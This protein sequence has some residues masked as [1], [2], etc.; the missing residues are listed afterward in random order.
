MALT[1]RGTE[2]VLS[3][4]SVSPLFQIPGLVYQGMDK[5][6]GPLNGEVWTLTFQSAGRSDPSQMSPAE[7]G[8]NL[9]AGDFSAAGDFKGARHTLTVTTPEDPTGDS[10]VSVTAQFELLGNELQKDIREHPIA[11]ALGYEKL[12]I[13]DGVLNGDLKS[14]GVKYSE[15]DILAGNMTHVY[16]YLRQRN[17]NGGYHKSQYVFRYTRITSNRAVIDVGFTGVERI[18]T[19]AQM[20]AQTGPP[21]G[22]LASIADAYTTSVPAAVADYQYGW[23]KKTPTVTNV[24]GNKVQISGEYWLEEWSTIF[25]AT[26]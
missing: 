19:T 13:I 3:D 24:A 21:P 10:E 20:V 9:I 18:H 5:R 8:Y 17:G 25:Y 1:I 16:R 23:M 15:S 4:G 2:E 14:P 7:T 11:L 22:I 26:A 6:K 12:K